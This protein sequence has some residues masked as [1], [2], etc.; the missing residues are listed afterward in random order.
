MNGSD[1]T[2]PLM[3]WLFDLVKKTIPAEYIHPCPYFGAMRVF[4]LT[5]VPTMRMIQFPIGYY[6][7]VL[8]F[9]DKVDNNICTAIYGAQ[10]S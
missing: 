7:A 10:L 2:N 5:F 4:N 8:R 6:K 1:T 3:S 9:F